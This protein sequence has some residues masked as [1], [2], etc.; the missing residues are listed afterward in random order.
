MTP[1]DIGEI[2]FPAFPPIPGALRLGEVDYQLMGY[3]WD[4]EP[5][6]VATLLIGCKLVSAAGAIVK[7][8]AGVLDRLPIIGAKQ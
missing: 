6:G 4:A 1:K 7:A 3:R 2:T 8:D 5:D